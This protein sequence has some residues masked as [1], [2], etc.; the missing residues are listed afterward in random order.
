M[1]VQ[2]SVVVGEQED[3]LL[4]LEQGS[5]LLG[6]GAQ[7]LGRRGGIRQT[8]GEAGETLEA[9]FTRRGVTHCMRA[10]CA[11]ISNS[12]IACSCPLPRIFTMRMVRRSSFSVSQAR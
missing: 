1:D 5:S 3:R 10:P 7:D 6:G 12:R 2:Q 11:S 8:A 4:R 9:F